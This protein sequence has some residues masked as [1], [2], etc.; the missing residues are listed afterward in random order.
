MKD[1][2]YLHNM[3]N[4]TS[5]EVNGEL[6]TYEYW[7]ERQLLSRIDKVEELERKAWE[8]S[9]E[10]MEQATFNSEAAES[11]NVTRPERYNG[12]ASG[13]KYAAYKLREA[14]DFPKSETPEKFKDVCP[15]C[16]NRTVVNNVCPDCTKNLCKPFIGEV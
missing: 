8:C 7:L 10:M 1:R 2:N 13:W 14:F 9:V 6:E 4:A 15:I 16:N 12:L 3:Y 11:G 5:T